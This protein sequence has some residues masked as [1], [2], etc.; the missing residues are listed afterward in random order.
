MRVVAMIKS[1][2]ASRVPLSVD[3]DERLP[4]TETPGA[5][6]QLRLLKPSERRGAESVP[7]APSD[8]ILHEGNVL[9]RGAIFP[10]FKERYFRLCEDKLLYSRSESALPIG[11]LT[12]GQG[13]SATSGGGLHHGNGMDEKGLFLFSIRDSHHR[14]MYC[15]CTSEA[16]RDEWVHQI[17]VAA[18]RHR[19]L[20]CVAELQQEDESQEMEQGA[21]GVRSD[22]PI[23]H[24]RA[25]F[26]PEL[27]WGAPP[28]W[29]LAGSP[30][31]CWLLPWEIATSMACVY[32]GLKVP[33]ASFM[34][35]V[36]VK[37]CLAFAR[38]SKKRLNYQVNLSRSRNLT[39]FPE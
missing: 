20:A 1:H 11:R 6:R 7:V 35:N 34:D 31:T 33:Y 16:V 32:V 5:P 17:S 36:K 3:E 15:A 10:A 12:I 39:S 13:L 14:H 9:K 4:A 19:N 24:A 23:H 28:S 29:Q 37:I 25:W 30:Q 8:H 26:F 22:G 21:G 38:G 18:E 27:P 2:S